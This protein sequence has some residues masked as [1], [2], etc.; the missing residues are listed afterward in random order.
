MS[1]QE[2][3]DALGLQPM[4]RES[5]EQNRTETLVFRILA[6][7]EGQEDGYANAFFLG[8]PLVRIA[9]APDKAS[10]LSNLPP[11]DAKTGESLAR[12]DLAMRLIRGELSFSEVESHAGG[13]GRLCSWML[14]QN[15]TKYSVTTQWLWRLEGTE[16]VLILDVV[17]DVPQQP[18]LRDHSFLVSQLPEEPPSEN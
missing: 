15:G 13:P 2:L 11:I 7:K 4:A 9:F 10:A 12:F 1:E 6:Q 8:G 5:S 17:D 3:L 18:M 14:H 16:K